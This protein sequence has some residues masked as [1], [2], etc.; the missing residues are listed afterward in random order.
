MAAAAVVMVFR[1]CTASHVQ[2]PQLPLLGGCQ[3]RGQLE[4]PDLQSQSKICSWTKASFGLGSEYN[5][6]WIFLKINCITYYSAWS[7]CCHVSVGYGTWCVVVSIL[8]FLICS[9]RLKSLIWK[10]ALQGLVTMRR[11]GLYEGCSLHS[12]ISFTPWEQHQ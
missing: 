10:T 8:N 1:I 2:R 12:S 9:W 7:Q 6:S 11:Y 5:L 4:I 3:E